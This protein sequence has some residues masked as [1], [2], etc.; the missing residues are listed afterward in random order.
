M[1][2]ISRVCFGTIICLFYVR[3]SLL[4][5]N[6]A[7]TRR[8]QASTTATKIKS[9][10]QIVP[11]FCAADLIGVER[12]TD[13]RRSSDSG[14]LAPG[15]IPFLLEADPESSGVGS[16]EEVG[17]GNSGRIFRMVAESPTWGASRIHGELWLL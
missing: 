12:L 5:E 9:A 14:W 16:Q 7:T 4:L 1:V 10:R 2:A 6:L 17:E 11:G 3:R 15:W 13:C 8:D